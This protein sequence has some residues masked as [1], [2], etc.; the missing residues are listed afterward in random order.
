MSSEATES[1]GK[2]LIVKYFH[3]QKEPRKRRHPTPVA[4]KSPPSAFKKFPDTQGLH[5]REKDSFFNNM[6]DKMLKPS[7]SAFSGQTH[8]EVKD[9]IGSKPEVPKL[10]YLRNIVCGKNLQPEMKLSLACKIQSSAMYQ[11]PLFTPIPKRP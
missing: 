7:Y 11:I 2:C 8:V 1:E 6:A 9:Q 10:E 5:R 3:I 4:P